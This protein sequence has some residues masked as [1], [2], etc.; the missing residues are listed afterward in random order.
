MAT[1]KALNGKPYAGNPHVRFDEGEVASAATPRRG[2]LLYK[3]LPV[4]VLAGA[5]ACG[6][7]ATSVPLHGVYE[8][9]GCS[10]GT[11][12][13]GNPTNSPFVTT[14]RTLAFPGVTLAK[15]EDAEF[16]GYMTGP[17]ISKGYGSSYAKHVYRDSSGDIQFIVASVQKIH[18]GSVKAVVFKLTEGDLG[19]Y[20]EALSARYLPTDDTVSV[21]HDFV[22]VNGSGK[23]IVSGK[24]TTIASSPTENG[25]AL[26]AF[27]AYKT[28]PT[29]APAL[30]FANRPGEATLT[31][32]DIADCIFSGVM[33]GRDVALPD[34]RYVRDGAYNKTVERDGDGS[35]RKITIEVQKVVSSLIKCV[36]IELTNGNGG[37]YAQ[38]VGAYNT[39]VQAGLGYSFVEHAADVSEVT[40]TDNPTEKS[41]G[42][43]GL[44]AVYERVVEEPGGLYAYGKPGF[45]FGPFTSGS[46]KLSP[47]VRS[48]RRLAF[49]GAKLEELADATFSGYLTGG[50]FGSIGGMYGRSYTNHAC[51]DEMGNLLYVAT[52]L[53]AFQTP[54]IKAVVVKF[55]QGREG[56]YVEG[57]AAGYL[58]LSNTDGWERAL[59]TN[60]FV[61]SVDADGTVTCDYSRMTFVENATDSGYALCALMARHDVPSAAASVV[62]TNGMA[63]AL[64]LD[65]LTNACFKATLTGRGMSVATGFPSVP[66]RNVVFGRNDSGVATNAWLEFQSL[67]GGTAPCARV[68]L[69][70]GD[71]GV[72]AQVVTNL[73]GAT[74]GWTFDAGVG[75]ADIVAMRAGAVAAAKWTG[76]ASG[77]I[78]VPHNWACVA[79]DGSDLVGRVPGHDALICLSG[80]LTNFN[81]TA[82]S[83][84]TRAATIAES[85]T[86]TED[87]DWSGLDDLVFAAGANMELHGHAL[88]V[89]VL[90]GFGSIGDSVGGGVLTVQTAAATTNESDWVSLEGSLALV[91]TGP[92]T[93]KLAKEDQSF[94]GGV[95]VSG[96]T[97]V[98]SADGA[99]GDTNL[100][101]VTVGASA[102]LELASDVSVKDLTV[103]GTLSGTGVVSVCG[104][105]RPLSATAGNVC[106]VGA[107]ATLDLASI[108]TP[109]GGNLSFSP[110]ASVT[111]ELGARQFARPTKLA[112]WSEPPPDTVQFAVSRSVAGVVALKM[113]SDGLY[114]SLPGFLMTFR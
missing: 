90:N 44:R 85:G 39:R 107:D 24:V 53:H 52:G 34:N 108:S 105:Y 113:K 111:I 14:N 66:A 12:S 2:S 96:G 114:A 112:A 46:P 35:V 16:L 95:T 13:Y 59:A 21:D 49:P 79:A 47:F 73:S 32:D 45:A 58:K 63:Q 33:C 17:Y 103:S 56:V 94:T 82:G 65:D 9:P 31:L 87:L 61:R 109:V 25:Y 43:M 75:V 42:V 29:G 77:D 89:G 48:A 60:D 38:A 92:G 68:E 106:L 72:A 67:G 86:L 64:V 70:N 4:L 97:L 37:V 55:T 26:T 57:V 19:T 8:A 11:Y 110:D 15:L 88:S 3:R 91:K 22:T 36:V 99:L 98:A 18:S 81:A 62:L 30:M 50:A 84:P 23:I 27:H 102:A 41:Y 83:T 10:F 40:V 54:N 28:V 74:A 93:L 69:T 78:S 20:V 80:G 6:A 101:V 5:L 76:L 7:Q 51:R 71:G 104:T 1:G 100:T